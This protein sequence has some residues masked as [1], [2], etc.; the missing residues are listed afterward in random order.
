MNTHRLPVS[1]RAI[2]LGPGQLIDW[3][4]TGPQRCVG[5][6][7]DGVC[8]TGGG[9][10][11]PGQIGRGPT[12]PG[13]IVRGQCPTCR[14]LG[15]YN[16]CI[17]CDGYRCDSLQR[18]NELVDFCARPRALY[19]ARFGAG[20]TKVG[21]SL[22]SR[23]V[24]RLDEQGPVAALVV[25]HGPGPRVKRAEADLVA[26]ADTVAG[27]TVGSVRHEQRRALLRSDVDAAAELARLLGMG[28]EV[29]ATIAAHDLEWAPSA[30]EP[31]PN[32]VNAR[33]ARPTEAL[34]IDHRSTTRIL[35][36]VVGVSG[37]TA[38]VADSA[39]VFTVD[40]SALLGT[41]L[42]VTSPEDA[43]AGVTEP[44]PP[45]VRTGVQLQFP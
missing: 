15:V 4:V 18:T 35:G 9:P 19:L 27:E 5:V 13:Q 17:A 25:A 37:T 45:I 42:T 14:S 12:G 26:S 7:R 24:Q 39:G 23:V 30:W 1:E 29:A 41:T 44:P 28:G 33:A 31:T 43:A 36:V 32:H 20:F 40:L 16:M 6:A 34:L 22:L 10:T 38:V 3:A 8:R 2:E 21:T 11:L